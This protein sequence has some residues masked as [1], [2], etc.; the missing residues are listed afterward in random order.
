[1]TQSQVRAESRLFATLDPTSR[2][3]RFPRDVEVIIT[4]TVGF[5]Q[6]LPKDLVVAFRATLEELESAD[7]LVHVIDI[8]NPRHLE[9]IR[10]VARILQELKL[11][12]IPQV[13]GLNKIDQVSPDAVSRCVER[14]DGIAICARD[15]KTLLPLIREMAA[16]VEKVPRF[17]V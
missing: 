9:Q 15:Q 14:L 3:L 1:L 13:R 4:D 7:L 5:I 6:N 10:S 12:H 17:N 8:S 16:I 2:R 11:N